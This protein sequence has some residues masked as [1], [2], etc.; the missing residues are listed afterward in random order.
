METCKICEETFKNLKGL[1]THINTKHHFNGKEYYDYYLKKDGEGQ[2][3]VCGNETTYRNF[4]VGYLK[5]CSIE[6]RNKNKTIKRDYWKGKTQSKETITKR[7]Q[8]TDQVAK[9]KNRKQT[10][11]DKYGVDNPCKLDI[12]KKVLSEKNKGKPLI[13][14][15]EWQNNI[16]ES[17][18]NNGTLKHS[19]ET[20]NKISDSLN[21]YYSENLDREKYITTSNNIKHLSGWYNGLYFRSSLELSF[22]VNNNEKS[23]S[24]CETKK[25][26]VNYSVKD[27]IKI[28]YP[29]YT[30]GEFIYEIKPTSL[31]N[32]SFNPIKIN[33]A[34]D[35]FGDFY[36]VITEEECNYISKDTVK[37]L[38]EK[39]N[40]VLVKNSEKIFEKY[41]H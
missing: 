26:A 25:Y 12:I 10:M 18:K 6:C 14:T 4:G 24:S 41:K 34:K 27:K 37:Q 9:E 32:F 38:I 31:L 30:D 39:G 17:K 3:D 40:V 21:K 29:D 22:L 28:Y 33:A 19:N 35:K 1:V 2:C 8:N 36:K 11:L 23:F 7:I 13:R 15:N 5:N 16:I 20:K